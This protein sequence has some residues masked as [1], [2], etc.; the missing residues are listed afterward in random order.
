MK[1]ALMS[2][3]IDTE[4]DKSIDWSNSNPL[5]FRS[6]TEGIPDILQPLFK[7]F[8]IKPTYF[9]SPEVINNFDCIE[10]LKSVD[11]YCELGTH[12]H[13]DYIEPQ[14]TF[15]DFSGM[16]TH[17]FQ[18]DFPPE[19]EFEKLKNLTNDFY[20]AFNYYPKVFRAGRYAANENT[21]KSLIKLGYK[22]DSSFTPH[23]KWESP[24]GNIINH[25]LSPEQPYACNADNIYSESESQLLEIPVSII[26]SSKFFLFKKHIWLRP[27]F[28]SIKEIKKIFKYFKSQ[29]SQKHT[30]V[31]NMMFHSQEVIPNASPYSRTKKDVENYLLFLEEVF[32][33]ARKEN[34]NFSTL[35]Q[36]YNV[37]KSSDK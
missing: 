1:R 11:K 35:E 21:I 7:K 12:L 17:S 25:E 6:V 34:I 36:I 4:C 8:S 22:V 27:K 15:R 30:I 3:T 5:T 31:F 20:S 19:I 26:K 37:F 9:L 18:T 24:L 13:A 33:L 16:E 23:L 32:S 2:V 14:K 29:Y 28:S 10:V